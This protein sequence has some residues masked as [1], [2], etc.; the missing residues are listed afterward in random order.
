L[1][2]EASHSSEING[3]SCHYYQHDNRQFKSTNTDLQNT[4]QKTKD[5]AT[6]TSLKPGGGE[7]Y[8]HQVRKYKNQV[9]FYKTS[10]SY[11]ACISL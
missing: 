7:M 6:R 11:V 4:T 10:N 3:T 9:N 5:Q 2:I 8:L 1:K